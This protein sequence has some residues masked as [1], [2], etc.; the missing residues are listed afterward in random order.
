MDIKGIGSQ[1]N[2]NTV[3]KAYTPTPVEQNT[4]VTQPKSNPTDT[5]QISKEARLKQNGEVSS[6]QSKNYTDKLNSGFYN[7][8]QVASVIAEKMF[9][10]LSK[11]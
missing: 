7:S 9:V 4:A 8:K 1:I 2:A 6:L 10:E 5:I 11:M 3:V